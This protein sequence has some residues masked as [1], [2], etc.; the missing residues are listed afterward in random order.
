MAYVKLSKHARA[1]QYR[2][3]NIKRS[4][5]ETTVS[6][7]SPTRAHLPF[8]DMTTSP[9]KTNTVHYGAA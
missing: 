8:V 7:Q 3:F 5:F 2:M 9:A 6:S 4:S 1:I